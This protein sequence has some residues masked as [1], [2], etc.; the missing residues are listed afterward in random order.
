[1]GLLASDIRRLADENR[2][3][4]AGNTHRHLPADQQKRR[5]FMQ[6][7]RL[8]LILTS[9]LLGSACDRGGRLLVLHDNGGLRVDSR[10]VAGAVRA[11]QSPREAT[12]GSFQQIHW[13][14]G[15]GG[16][17]PQALPRPSPVRPLDPGG[18]LAQ[19][20]RLRPRGQ[21]T[22]RPTSRAP[23]A[24]TSGR[25]GADTESL[26]RQ[27][28]DRGGLGRH[29]RAAHLQRRLLRHHVLERPGRLA[30]GPG[31]ELAR[32]DQ[33]E[34]QPPAHRLDGL[35]HLQGGAQPDLHRLPPADDGNPRRR[36]RR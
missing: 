35:R 1:M 23:A 31:D 7:G 10:G 5:G 36:C 27:R 15:S 33:H 9:A 24:T 32:G 26:A 11:G 28:L 34:R 20:G 30:L 14:P 22:N 4:W 8:G 12:G 25:A 18:R 17:R 19:T 2:V 29:Q 16:A 3:G 13:R 21:G 6:F